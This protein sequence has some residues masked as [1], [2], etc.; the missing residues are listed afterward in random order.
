[1][2]RSAYWWIILFLFWALF[3][4]IALAARR[5]SVTLDEPLHV[6]SGYA[7]LLTGDY[8]LVE[9]HPPLL[10]MFQAAPLLLANP[11]VPDPREAVGWEEAN[12]ITVA[13]EIIVPYPAF[14]ALVF[15]TRVPTMLTA[16]LLAA[17]V[18]RWAADLFGARA[19]LFALLLLAFDPNILAH[20]GVAATDLGATCAI[21]G[22]MYLFWRWIRDPSGPR[23]R[24]ALIAAVGLG[25]AL[26]VKT[27]VLMLGPIY[28]GFVLLG[29]PKRRALFPYLLQGAGIVFVAFLTL[30]ASYRFE[31]GTI[32][33]LPFPIP[34]PSHLLPLRKL[35]IHMQEGHAA[36]LMGENYHHGI[37]YYFPVAFAIKTPPLTLG[38]ILVT[39]IGLL[40]RWWRSPGRRAE[41]AMLALPLL[42]FGISL[43][44]GINIGYRHLLPILP[45]LFVWL[46]RIAPRAWNARP[47]WRWAGVAAVLGYISVTLWLHPWH[48]AYFNAFIGGPDNG[49]HY[50]VDS[51]LDWGQTWKALNTYLEEQQIEEFGL[52]QYTINDP[53]QYGLDY[54]P[55]PPWPDAPPV[56]PQRFDPPPG[57]YA[58]STTQLQGVVIA[59]PEMFDYFRRLEPRARIGHAMHVYDLA[60][61][62]STDWVAQCADPVAPLP[63]AH[64]R[65]GLGITQSVPNYRFDCRESW[66]IPPG[67]GRYVLSPVGREPSWSLLNRARL[68]YEQVHTGGLPPFAIYEWSPAAD[69]MLSKVQTDAAAQVGASLD[70]LG[71]RSERATVDATA[72]IE[73]Y[74][75][76][77]SR[78]D[79]PLSLMAHLAHADGRPIAVGDGLGVPVDQWPIAGLII[80]RHTFEIPAE[81]APGDYVLNVGAYTL[82]DLTRLP[83]SREEIGIGDHVTAGEITVTAP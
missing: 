23:W 6:A 82:P 56:L 72:V 43:G 9:E 17:L 50:L 5:T 63:E 81:T 45:F 35:R 69:D 2:K 25:L 38:L 66:L 22:A 79:D 34:A 32:P 10:K 59:A 20:A 30:W 27:T 28:A 54:T 19:G 15:I 52:S 60:P 3:A 73:T 55:L 26:G 77:R 48:L 67:Y 71:Y 7:T 49:Y 74:W 37:W 68:A 46:S 13:Q 83:V 1:M 62:P 8:R 53:H 36:F 64:V 40:R 47:F 29:R 80:Q 76:V 18:Y 4:Q 41:S 51:N 39:A 33:E 78:P 14:D 21:F 12:L 58:I 44:S 75:R 61:H 24:R 31:V 16:L 57:I 11:P 65:E 70:F 42:Y